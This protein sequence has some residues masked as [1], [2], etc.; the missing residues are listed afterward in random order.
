MKLS[1]EDCIDLR[2]ALVTLTPR[3]RAALLWRL[4]GYTQREIGERLT[5]KR[6]AVSRLLLRAAQR[7]CAQM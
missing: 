5:V 3:Q 4:D 2:A 7:L 6:S 1:I